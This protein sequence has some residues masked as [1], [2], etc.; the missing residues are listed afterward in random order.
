MKKVTVVIVGIGGYG[1]KMTTDILDNT[2]RYG[3]TVVGVVDPFYDT[4]DIKDRIESLNIPHYFTLEDFYKKHTA[5]LAVICTPIQLHEEHCVTAMQNGSDCLCEKP[6][7]ATVEQSDRMQKLSKKLGRNLNIGFQLCYIPAILDL[8]RDILSGE[9]GR[10]LSV[11]SLVC[12]P[13][14]SKYYARPWCAKLRANGKLVLDSIAMNAC[15]HYL[16]VLLFLLGD[17]MKSAAYPASAKALVCRANDIE[18]FDTAMLELTV[19]DTVVRYNV[20]HACEKRQDPLFKIEFENCTVNAD[21]YNDGITA[22]FRDGTSR[23]Y[24]NIMDAFY[25]KIPYS[26][27]I[28]RGEKPPVCDTETARSHLLC[29]NAVTEKVPVTKLVD[30]YVADDVVVADGLYDTLNYC[31]LR[32]KMPWE[33]T[34]RYGMPVSIDFTDYNGWSEK[35]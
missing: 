27:D 12:W 19:N 15:A 9:F 6:T 28:V 35:E 22:V 30:T 20:T 10:P 11:S 33:I 5:D 14:D 13:R 8:K 1:K 23:Y 34:D 3:I 26:C 32:D 25:S 16:Q 18:T 7:A 24:G 31:Y 21:V 4:C 29:I 17:E 2:D